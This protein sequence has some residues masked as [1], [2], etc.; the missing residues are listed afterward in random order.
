MYMYVRTWGG[1]GGGDG[2]KATSMFVSCSNIVCVGG[3]EGEIG[4][5]GGHTTPCM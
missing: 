5:G 2:V 4:V 3:G 1:G